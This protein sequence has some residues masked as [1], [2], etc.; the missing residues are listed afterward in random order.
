MSNTKL[1]RLGLLVLALVAVMVV[2]GCG[3]DDSEEAAPAATSG[4]ATAT[5]DTKG[6]TAPAGFVDCDAL[7]DPKGCDGDPTEGE[8]TALDSSEVTKEW[9]LCVA[10]PHLKDSYWLATNYGVAEESRRLGVKM[11][12]QD[13]GGYTNLSKQVSQL[14]NCVAQGADATVIGAISFDGL[15]SKVDEFTDGGVPVIDIMNGISNPKVAA[16]SV[17]SFYQIGIEVGTH[18]VE[19]DKPI[20]VAFFPGPPGAGWV[21]ATVKGF[22]EAIEGSQVNAVAVKY[23]DTGKDVQ[24][25]LVENALETYPDLDYIAG[26]AVTAEAAVGALRERG[27]EDE[28]KVVSTYMIPE[29]FDKLEAGDIE[30]AATDKPVLQARVGIDMAVRVLEKK[31]LVNDAKRAM[32][33]VQ[34]V[35]GPGSESANNI[36]EFEY[37]HTFAP[38]GYKPEF[39]VG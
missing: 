38:E 7:S 19:L 31:P 21:E 1:W 4:E 2:A 15:D 3:G 17:V 29:T 33:A 35:C 36:S 32:P 23:G 8:Y 5:A 34:L 27:Q 37:E 13:A 26:S 30:C 16:R 24:L 18:L 6:W 10:F 25:K 11:Q 28:I 22:N 9:N 14:D 39:S 12:L 20:N